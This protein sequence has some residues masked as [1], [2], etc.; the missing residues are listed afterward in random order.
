MVVWRGA[1][2][3][4]HFSKGKINGNRRR[5]AEVNQASAGK[6]RAQQVICNVVFLAFVSAQYSYESCLACGQASNTHTEVPQPHA[7]FLLYIQHC[8]EELVCTEAMKLTKTD[9][10]TR[11]GILHDHCISL[12]VPCSARLGRKYTRN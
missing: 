2:L 1:A 4:C 7:H 6:V 9:C 8:N 10:N 12:H 3:G 5:V 11:N